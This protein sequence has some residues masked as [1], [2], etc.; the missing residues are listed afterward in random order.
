MVSWCLLMTTEREKCANCRFWDGEFSDCLA[1]C[2]R[3]APVVIDDLNIEEYPGVWP[4]TTGISWCG[5]WEKRSI[6]L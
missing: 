5:E 2:R 6:P 4:E 1:L 3:N